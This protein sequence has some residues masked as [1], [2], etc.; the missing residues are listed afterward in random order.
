M[1]GFFTVTLFPILSLSHCPLWKQITK[2]SPHWKVEELC[3]LRR[4]HL[5]ELLIILLYGRFVS[6]PI[7]KCIKLFISINMDTWIF[8][9]Y[10]G[11][12]N[13]LL[14]FLFCCSRCS[15]FSKREFF[16]VVPLSL[17]LTPITLFFWALSYSLTD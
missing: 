2:H 3:F 8:T 7:L 6:S 11:G 12:Y 10:C 5:C 16:Q 15:I 9:L 4:E 17:W 1:P 14:L 13:T